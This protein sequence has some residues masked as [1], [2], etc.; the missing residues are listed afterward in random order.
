MNSVFN[1]LTYVWRF[2]H[3]EGISWKLVKSSFIE[4]K[5]FVFWTLTYLTTLFF[6]Q[7][8]WNVSLEERTFTGGDRFEGLSKM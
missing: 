4:M 8:H 2:G 7:F 5:F 1:M 3:Q 6:R